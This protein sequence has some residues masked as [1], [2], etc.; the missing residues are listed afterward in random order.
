MSHPIDSA[1]SASVASPAK[2]QHEIAI[3]VNDPKIAMR[4]EQASGYLELGMAQQA[5]DRLEGVSS[6]G[7]AEGTLQ[8]LRGQALC[9]LSRHQE[10]FAPLHA[11][12]ML[13]PPP[14]DSHVWRTLSECYRATGCEEL[15]AQSL[16]RSNRVGQKVVIQRRANCS[17]R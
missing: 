16:K 15:A 11:A 2:I 1:P 7:M 17:S 14:I 3:T 13:I 10:A 12:A 9:K 4:I 5:F 6:N 8:Y